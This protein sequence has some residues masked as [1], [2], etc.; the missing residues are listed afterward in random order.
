MKTYLRELIKKVNLSD[1]LYLNCYAPYNRIMVGSPCLLEVDGECYIGNKGGDVF[2]N[3]QRF[4]TITVTK[5]ENYGGKYF[6]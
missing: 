2:V 6:D 5:K 1:E 3:I 4:E